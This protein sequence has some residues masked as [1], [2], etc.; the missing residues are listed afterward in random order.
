MRK[1]YPYLNDP[2]FLT[3]IVSSNN[4]VYYT[5]ISVLNWD[6][7]LLKEIT[8]KI[9]SGSITIDGKSSIR[10]TGTIAFVLQEND[11]DASS[12][13]QLNKKIYLQL[14]Y[15]N[16][17]NKYPEYP[18]IWFSQGVNVITNISFS[19]SV[20]NNTVTLS[21]KD[22]MCLLNGQCGGILPAATV[23]DNY[24][25]Q[26]ENGNIV[27]VRPTIFQIIMQLVNHFGGEQLGNIII[28]DLDTRIKRVMRWTGSV[29]L[30]VLKGGNRGGYYI[31]TDETE[32]VRLVEEEHFQYE[33]G[34]PFEAGA[35]VGYILDDFAYPG[36]LIGNVG[37]TVVSILDKIKNKLGN[38][39]YFYDTNGCFRF[40]E[41]KNYL[42]NSQSKYILES[43][44]DGKLVPDYLAATGESYLIQR[45]NGKAVFS[46][47][48]NNNLIT[49]Y[50]NTPQ[51]QNIKN[52]YI[53]W[54]LRKTTDGSEYPIRYHLAIDKKPA[55]GN[56]Y[57]VIKYV[58]F[59][60]DTVEK[61]YKPVIYPHRSDLPEKGLQGVLY[62][63][64]ED[65]PKKVYAWK[66]VDELFQYV[67]IDAT[68]QQIV[69]TD[70]R[71]QL[72]FQGVAAQPNGV[73]SNFYYAELM[74][75]WPKIYDIQH[76][77]FR[78]QVI[79]NPS[80]IDYYLDFINPVSETARKLSVGNIGRRT[81]VLNKNNDVNCVFEP[82]VPDVIMIKINFTES[83]GDETDMKKLRDECDAKGW[84]YC[85]IDSDVYNYLSD[86]YNLNSGYE[87]VKQSLYQYVNFLESVS[88]QTLPIYFL[89]P[90]TCIE[91]QDK[92]SFISG[93]YIINSLSFS[94]DI[95]SQLSINASKLLERY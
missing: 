58:D 69:T 21:F 47:K 42:N 84:A 12:F 37:E 43:L 54:G 5:K 48:D 1:N 35:N 82:Y 61:W 53:V 25:T 94:F 72:Y 20:S 10:R 17:T 39:E 45:T 79:K 60:D 28:S 87:E 91:I 46:F 68:P 32:A 76:K 56:T 64:S 40:Q 85:Q 90:N 51:I 44:Q 11:Q 26:D 6:Q 13:L 78:E 7:Q 50:S 2:D 24:E 3:E 36:D 77:T 38:F 80:N 89:E 16:F 23:F 70:W 74:A 9:T 88:L 19:H 8:G 18:I 27:V 66:N 15:Y 57:W 62:Y 49:S 73:E 67:E 55:V 30:Y 63:T 93:N 81:V 41:I 52:D 14:G 71:T 33:P 29:P 75:E 34:C 4:N 92:D 83:E 95:S 22:K 86:G 65:V 31:T 59:Y